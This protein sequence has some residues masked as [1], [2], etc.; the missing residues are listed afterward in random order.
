MQ[1]DTMNIVLFLANS[2]L[3]G[4]S[5]PGRGK[6]ESRLGPTTHYKVASISGVG[7]IPCANAL[8]PIRLCIDSATFC[9]LSLTLRV[10][11]IILPQRERHYRQRLAAHKVKDNYPRSY[12]LKEV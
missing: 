8:R 4:A 12:F 6:S 7:H 9:D 5:F 1:D 11:A 2:E 3:C 10:I